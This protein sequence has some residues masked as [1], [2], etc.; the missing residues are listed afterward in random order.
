MPD[1]T[2][3]NTTFLQ[4]KTQNHKAGSLEELVE[5]LVKTWEMEA[6]HKLDMS[7]WRTVDP[8]DYFLQTNG[9]ELIDGKDVFKIGNYNALMVDSKVYQNYGLENDFELSHD[10]FR[11]AFPKGFAWELLKVL[12]K[13]PEVIFTWRH[14]GVFAGS[15]RGHQGHN[16]TIEMFGMCRVTVNPANLKIRKIEAFLDPDSFLQVL[17]GKLPPEEI[18]SGQALLGSIRKTAIEK[19]NKNI[20][21]N[22]SNGG[23][24]PFKT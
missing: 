3:A 23:G 20:K 21:Q 11:G 18:N 15:Y 19:L 8:D 17:E 1:Y 9:G 16:E 24:C 10:L 12:S 2:L 5:N 6:T 14:W 13:P 22:G 7:Q 4:G